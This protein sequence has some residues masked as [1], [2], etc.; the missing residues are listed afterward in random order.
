[1]L[2][3][4]HSD[5]LAVVGVSHMHAHPDNAHSEGVVLVLCASNSLLC[6][7]PGMKQ[8]PVSDSPREMKLKCKRAAVK[9]TDKPDKK[10]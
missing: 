2:N 5:S 4:L 7:F 3:N 8:L 9:S 6:I 10:T 1:M